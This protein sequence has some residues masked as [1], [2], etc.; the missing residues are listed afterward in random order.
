[1]FQYLA[2]PASRTNPP[3]FSFI[4]YSLRRVGGRH[5]GA[6]LS[7]LFR[8]LFLQKLFSV[9]QA[10]HLRFFGEH[11]PLAGINLHSA[12]LARIFS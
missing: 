1:M 8:R 3:T 5:L 9:H 7:R 6:F 4:P 10:G 2:N 11:A 12:S